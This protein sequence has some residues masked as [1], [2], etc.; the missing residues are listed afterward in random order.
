MGGREPV[1]DQSGLTETQS[2]SQPHLSKVPLRRTHTS[3]DK[4]SKEDFE[5]NLL[6]LMQ[7]QLELSKRMY[8]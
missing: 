6:K 2:I 4:F 1:A 5:K 8:E 3:D 7:E